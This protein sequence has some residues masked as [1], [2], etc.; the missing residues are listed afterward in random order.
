MAGPA[1][2]ARA[3]PRRKRFDEIIGGLVRRSGSG[4]DAF[5]A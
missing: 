3:V 2:A 1:R 4:S 5:R